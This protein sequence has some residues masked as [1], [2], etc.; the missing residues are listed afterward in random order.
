MARNDKRTTDDSILVRSL[1]GLLGGELERLMI[2]RDLQRDEG[3]ELLHSLLE[4]ETQFARARPLLE[5]RGL[6]GTLVSLAITPGVNGPWS[7][8]EIQQSPPLHLSPPLL[9][10]DDDILLAVT[11]DASSVFDAVHNGLGAGTVIGISRPIAIATGFRESVRQARLA[12]AQARETGAGLLRYGDAETG[13]IMAP[14]SLAEAR[15]LVGC[16][17]GPLMEYDRTHGGE[18]CSRR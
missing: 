7:L 18:T 16:Y 15:A 17:L 6:S 12:L 9:A 8:A 4:S 3:A 5:R 10:A 11:Q 2:Q 1:V 13:L 14:K